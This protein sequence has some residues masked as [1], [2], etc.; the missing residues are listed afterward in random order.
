[1]SLAQKVVL[2][3]DDKDLLEEIEDNLTLSG[4]SVEAF[5]DPT[6]ALGK[7]NP[8]FDGVVLS[9]L[10]MP[11]IS[12]QELLD[13]T[14]DIDPDIPFVMITGH[15]QVQQ[16]TA[17]MKAGAYD[18]LEKPI[19]PELLQAVIKRALE[20]RS[21]HLKLRSL[22]ESSDD[23][24]LDAQL[25]GD[26][27]QM[28]ELREQ[29][30]IL[31]P[32]D[33]DLVLLGETG[34]GKDQVARCLHSNSNSSDGPFIAVNC[35][36]LPENLVDGAFFGHERGAFTGAEERRRGYFEQA[37]GGT[38]FLDELESMPLAFQTRLLR[39]LETREF[40]RL[41]GDNSI[42]SQFRVVAA[43][44]GDLDQLVRD[45][46]LRADLVF[47]L[48]IAS[49]TIPPLRER[50]TDI[51]LLFSLFVEKSA[52][53]H[54]KHAPTIKSGLLDQLSRYQWPGNV[55]ELKN[56]AERF[57]IG[58]PIS[59]APSNR[60]ETQGSFEQLDE[61]VNEFERQHIIEALRK[62]NGAIGAAA[63][64]LGVPRKKLYLRMQKHEIERQFA[65]E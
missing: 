56:C 13:K 35:G 4:F 6:L 41:G 20:K 19:E 55:R 40:M 5:T 1:M 2:I 50:L 62:T 36:A 15:G 61:A 18:F 53:K 14:I 47:R 42:R 38:L 46:F 59:F 28:I 32:L 30:R 25:V 45:G 65:S 58:L 7:L 60:R 24:G 34:S 49:L 31:S 33:V 54:N 63:D 10:R 22:L 23:S 64:L 29:I 12:G 3:D 43:V 48:N 16:A 39:V 21:L 11:K 8:R 26:A 9:D 37:D 57:A 44:K 27:P 52:L 51:P 17:A